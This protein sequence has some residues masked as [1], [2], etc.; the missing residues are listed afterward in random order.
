MHLLKI[1]GNCNFG[2]ADPYILKS[3][4]RYYI[5]V[6][7]HDAIYA[8]H[9]DHLQEGWQYHGQV[10][11]VPGL[12]AYWAPSVIELDGKFYMYNSMEGADVIPDKYGHTGAM[13]VS[14][15]DNPL[16]PF[17]MVKRI[18]DPFSIDSHIVK[19]ESG[20]YLFY[21]SNRFEGDRI[22]TC[23]YVDKMLDPFTPAGNPVLVVE[24]TLDEDIFIR[25]QYRPGEHW[26]TI[27]GA[28]YFREGEWQ[29]VMYSGNCFEQPTYYVGYARA[30]TDETD[31][32]KIKFEKYPNAQ[33]YHP[34]L[35]ANEFEEGTGHHSM[36]KEGNQWY[37]IY[38]ARDYGD[39]AA[40][41]SFDARNAR[42][43][44]MTVENGVITAYRSKD[45]I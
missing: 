19:N 29:Y 24:P 35:R 15:A 7:G 28:F 25:D 26:H 12:H 11:S 5:Y 36:I 22:G 18:L 13:H 39:A 27:E 38:H 44:K 30:K 31:L 37:A 34:V 20:L 33:T 9:S 32:T 45:H 23:I 3:G 41:N 43:C 21:S 8:Y 17:Q 6:T 4:E 2:Q 40:T 14:V 10:L 16:G 42:I 1:D